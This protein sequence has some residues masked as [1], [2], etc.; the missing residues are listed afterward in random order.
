MLFIY[1]KHIL[2]ICYICDFNI[3]HE[4]KQLYYFQT[5]DIINLNYDI[6]K[7]V[8]GIINSKEILY[9]KL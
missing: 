3:Y 9:E 4:N 2:Y 8:I 7:L 5:N 1:N 6:M